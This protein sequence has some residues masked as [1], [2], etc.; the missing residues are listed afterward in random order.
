MRAS[1][2]IAAPFSRKDTTALPAVAGSRCLGTLYGLYLRRNATRPGLGGTR[3]VA[4]A[5]ITS[6]GARR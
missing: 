4:Q 5:A 1:G 2:V 6:S 3:I